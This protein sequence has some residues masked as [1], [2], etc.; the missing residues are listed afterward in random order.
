MNGAGGAFLLVSCSLLTGRYDRYYCPWAP[1]AV[2]PCSFTCLVLRSIYLG[3]PTILVMFHRLGRSKRLARGRRRYSTTSR[4]APKKYLGWIK[5]KPN[6]CGR[7]R[8]Y[9]V[10]GRPC[11]SSG[12][13]VVLQQGTSKR[14]Q[15]CIAFSRR[16]FCRRWDK[17]LG[18]NKQIKNRSQPIRVLL[19][20]TLCRAK[21]LRAR[22]VSPQRQDFLPIHYNMIVRI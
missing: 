4:I 11:N 10:I 5:S 18:E 15:R 9:A 6:T 1:L 7:C 2:W 21:Y 17:G 3:L 14:T 8:L 22:L 20:W 16:T 19:S 12:T 13:P